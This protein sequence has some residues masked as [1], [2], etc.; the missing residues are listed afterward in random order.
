V[1]TCDGQPEGLSAK[2]HEHL[3]PH[4]MAIVDRVSIAKSSTERCSACGFALIA[5]TKSDPN[6]SAI[7]SMYFANRP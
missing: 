2:E 4:L 6:L 5:A 1:A 7:V 3:A